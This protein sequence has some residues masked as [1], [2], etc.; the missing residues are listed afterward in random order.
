MERYANLGYL[1]LKKQTAKNTPV[2]P[3]VFVPL[4]EESLSTNANF[5]SQQPV[6]GSKFKTRT[7]LRGQRDHQGEL[8]V[9]AEPN[10]TAYFM[11]MLLTKGATTGADPYTHPYDYSAATN[12]NGYTIDLAEGNFVKRFWGVE[13][14][15]LAPEWEDNEMRHKITVSAL[16]SYQG[17]SIASVATT[18]LVLDTKYDANPT[19]GLVI[20][21]LVR[22]YKA[23]DGSTLDTTVA[24]ITDGTTVVLGASAAAFEAGDI[25]HLRPATPNF[26]LLDTFL[27]ART[28]FRFGAD[29]A[30]ALAATHTPVESGSEWELMHEF[31]E[32]AGEK[33]SGS[34]DPA[35][36]A[37]KGVD[38]TITVKRFFDTLEDVQRFNDMTKRSVVVRCFAGSTNQY[39]FRITFHNVTVD[40]PVAPIQS[41]GILYA[42]QQ[43]RPNNDTTDGK[44]LS[45]VLINAV[46]TV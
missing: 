6:Y 37:R 5:Q 42:T 19:K 18:T 1:G 43:L 3:N 4:Y 39:E 22:V 26:S 11:D 36:L 2:T 24:S 9:V 44:G 12:P 15:V 45:V 23:S 27:W 10:T 31:N 8:T 40:T 46:A 25:L 35:S 32:D 34:F 41:D 14:S 13:A 29:A 7:T 17:R 28:E 30:A 38:A 20:G 16:G 21:D 33:R